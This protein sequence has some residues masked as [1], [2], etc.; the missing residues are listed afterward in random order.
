M[1]HKYKIGQRIYTPLGPG[2]I[3]VLPYN[4]ESDRYMVW[5]DKPYYPLN[6]PHLSHTLVIEENKISKTPIPITN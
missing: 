2:V 4:E 6:G 5:L 3:D 1:A